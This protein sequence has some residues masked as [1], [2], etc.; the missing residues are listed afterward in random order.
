MAILARSGRTR[1]IRPVERIGPD[2][3]GLTG[4]RSGISGDVDHVVALVDHDPQGTFETIDVRIGSPVS[5]LQDDHDPLVDK[6]AERCRY[7]RY[8][9]HLLGHDESR[10]SR[11]RSWAVM[12]RVDLRPPSWM[13]GNSPARIMR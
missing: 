10:P 4:E 7:W 11:I 13:V 8:R 9:G 1:L 3:V 12:M 5:Q 2:P 6:M